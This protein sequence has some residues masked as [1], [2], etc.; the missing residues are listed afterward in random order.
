MLELGLVTVSFR[1]KVFDMKHRFLHIIQ[2]LGNS[3]AG[4]QVTGW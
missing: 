2:K 4:A 3:A 1:R